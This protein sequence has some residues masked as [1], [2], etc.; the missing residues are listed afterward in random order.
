MALLHPMAGSKPCFARRKNVSRRGCYRHQR[1]WSRLVGANG[2]FRA[3]KVRCATRTYLPHAATHARSTRTHT[4][5]CAI[6]HALAGPAPCSCAD[7]RPLPLVC[8]FRGPRTFAATAHA[9]CASTP[10]AAAMP[11]ATAA[12]PAAAAPAAATAPTVATVLALGAGWGDRRGR[13]R[14]RG[15]FARSAP[16]FYALCFCGL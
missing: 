8:R 6:P 15:R 10:A 1:W 3:D 14:G 4:R 16:R 13:G 2:V 9:S 5:A 7:N 12:M 11:A